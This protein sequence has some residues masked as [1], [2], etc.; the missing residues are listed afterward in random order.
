MRNDRER[1]RD[2]FEAIAKI[3]KYA[4]RG[5]A[6]FFDNELIQGWTLLQLQIIEILLTPRFQQDLRKL[7]KRYRSICRDLTPL[8]EQL[9][10]RKKSSN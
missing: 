6:E 2:I 10:Q 3:E 5:K 4:V 1:M 7:A 8:I 9:Q